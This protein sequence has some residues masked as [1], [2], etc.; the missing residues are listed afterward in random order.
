[1]TTVFSIQ[2]FL[3]WIFTLLC[4]CVFLLRAVGLN[5]GQFCPPGDIW[6]CLETFLVVTLGVRRVLLASSGQRPGMLPNILLMHRMASHT[7]NY[8]AQNVN[9]AE[10]EK[11]SSRESGSKILRKRGELRNCNTQ[12]HLSLLNLKTNR[13]SNS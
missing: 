11:P 7:K 3:H 2:C 12:E 5:S 8:S 6:Q 4:V 10:V 13:N 1:M 9:S